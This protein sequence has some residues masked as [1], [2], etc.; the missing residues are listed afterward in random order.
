MNML[1][2]L[3]YKFI[4]FAMASIAALL[5]IL[6]GVINFVNFSLV[7]SDADRVLDGIVADGGAFAFEQPS[8]G[9]SAGEVPPQGEFTQGGTEPGGVPTFGRMGPDSPE[10]KRSMRYF[11]VAFSEDG[12]ARLV[13]RDT[14]VI[15]EADAVEWARTLADA[16]QGWT[17]TTYRFKTYESGGETFVTVIDYSRELTPSYNVLWASIIGTVGGLAITFIVLLAVGEKLVKPY[18]VSDLKQKK[19]IT[20][21]SREIKTPLTVLA[22]DT[23][24]IKEDHG[25]SEVTRSMDR[26]IGKMTD[27]S[28]RLNE[29]TVFSSDALDKKTVD[30]SKV[31]SDVL[32]TSE[33]AFNERNIDSDVFIQPSVK[34]LC[35]ETLIKKVFSEIAENAAKFAKTFVRSSL[36]QNGQRII[37]TTENDDDIFPDGELDRVFDRFFKQGDK[38]GNGLGLAIVKEIIV[39]HGGRVKAV[40]ADGKFILKIELTGVS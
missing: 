13:T 1:K 32:A 33:Q 23:E 36:T 17:K 12:S 5:V 20:D 7:A 4:A 30:L 9:E 10:M 26:Q 21:A 28:L 22:L 2:R 6:L 35:D 39:G 34:A 40:K 27:L 31:V 24:M 19:F 18:A 3:K 29:L 37:F 38:N 16:K 11:T 14:S 25:E 8:Q 15:G